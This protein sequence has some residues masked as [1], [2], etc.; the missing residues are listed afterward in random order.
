MPNY[1]IFTLTGLSTIFDAQ[2]ATIITK[3]TYNFHHRRLSLVPRN[4]N[5]QNFPQCARPYCN[6]T[7]SLSPSRLGCI[8]VNLTQKCLCETAVAP[9]ACVPSGPSSED[10][11]WYDVEDWLAGQCNGS[12]AVVPKQSM[13]SCLQDCAVNWLRK[14]GCRTDTRNCF[15]KLDNNEVIGAV[16]NCKRDGCMKH[17]S[18]SFDVTSWRDQVCAQGKVDTYDEGAYRAREKQVRDIR[19][20]VPVAIGIVG[21]GLLIAAAC[22]DSSFIPGV[23]VLIVVLIL[24]IIPPIFVAI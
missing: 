24:C 23:L 13:P 14:K 12:V 19:I 6:E 2:A 3:E 21:L 7:A 10:N 5:F 20:G 8:E 1:I 15:C 22:T 9:L 11:C 17:M 4:I 16:D 18:P